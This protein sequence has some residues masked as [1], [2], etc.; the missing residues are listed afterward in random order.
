MKKIQLADGRPMYQYTCIWGRGTVIE[1]P[2]CNKVE[3]HISSAVVAME[4]QAYGRME[5]FISL[6]L[7]YLFAQVACHLFTEK[8][9][10]Y[11]SGGFNN[12]AF[13][14]LFNESSSAKLLLF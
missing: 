1:I 4:T 12:K 14:V 3:F 8:F 5:D 6:G 10:F 7:L 9:I 11:K 13:Y 2:P